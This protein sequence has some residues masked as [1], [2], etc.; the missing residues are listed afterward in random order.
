MLNLYNKINQERD[1]KDSHSLH[2]LTNKFTA[3]IYEFPI[4]YKEMLIKLDGHVGELI[5]Y[6]YLVKSKDK[7]G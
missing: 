6:T 1:Y 5:K 7:L 4:T 2:I 3:K